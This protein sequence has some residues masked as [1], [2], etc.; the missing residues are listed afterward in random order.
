MW[1]TK[2][3][4]VVV[5]IAVYGVSLVGKF[6]NM[7]KLLPLQWWQVYGKNLNVLYRSTLV[8]SNK[9]GSYYQMRW[10]TLYIYTFGHGFMVS[11]II[12][13]PSRVWLGPLTLGMWY[14]MKWTS[15]LKDTFGRIYWGS[16][17]SRC[18]KDKKEWTIVVVVEV[19]YYDRCW[20]DMFLK[21][22]AGKKNTWL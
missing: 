7:C 18:V 15:W 11:P 16:L 21:F 8:G 9:L 12:S 19:L 14:F 20:F 6:M 4:N 17:K 3:V 13:P 10:M 22:K 2:V 5:E 1:P